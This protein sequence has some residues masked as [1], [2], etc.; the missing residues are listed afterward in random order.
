M[1]PRIWGKEK[2]ID[3]LIVRLSNIGDKEESAN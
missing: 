1:P 3:K 2:A